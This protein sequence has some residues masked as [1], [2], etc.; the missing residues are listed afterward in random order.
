MTVRTI[1]EGKLQISTFWK[2]QVHNFLDP[3]FQGRRPPREFKR[4]LLEKFFNRL[5]SRTP[6]PVDLKIKLIQILYSLE[7]IASVQ[8]STVSDS[9]S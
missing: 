4:R 9:G 3:L 2:G 6:K 5:N 7:D 8:S 1:L